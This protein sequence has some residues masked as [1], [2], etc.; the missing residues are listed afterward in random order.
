MYSSVSRIMSFLLASILASVVYFS[1]ASIQDASAGTFPG[2]NGKIAFARQEGL[3]SWIFTINPDGTGITNTTAH[4]T[5]GYPCLSWSPD[6][7]KIAF[8][9]RPSGLYVM[10]ADG[11]SQT[12]LANFTSFV[13]M[14]T[15][16]PDGAKIAFVRE[17]PPDFRFDIWVINADGTGGATD[18]TNTLGDDEE[19]P[20]WSPDVKKIAFAT[21]EGIFVMNSADGTNRTQLTNTTYFVSDPNWSP[22]GTKI[23]FDGYPSSIRHIFVMDADGS[24]QANVTSGPDDA[25]PS[26]SPDGTKIVYSDGFF[27]GNIFVIN[28]NGSGK[29]QLT[30]S[31]E[32]S[33]PEWGPLAVQPCPPNTH[34]DPASGACVPNPSTNP[35]VGGEILGVDMTTLFV[36][37]AFANA[38][39]I[40]PIAGVA[41]AGIV[42]FVLRKRIR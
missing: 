35:P 16:S 15:W 9:E 7:T 4:C 29:T 13:S 27:A 41:A 36:A 11:S 32:D 21:D 2:V 12:L 30:N 31:G 3:K 23:A 20:S 6:G 26:W 22:D 42:G 25:H 40:I 38:S 33:Y 8:T 18:L 17:T 28:N 14:P 34:R 24:N 5:S 37:G 19:V 10:N 39:W 1:T